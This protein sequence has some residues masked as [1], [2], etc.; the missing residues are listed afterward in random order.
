MSRDQYDNGY[1][2]G[3]RHASKREHDRYAEID[4]RKTREIAQLRKENRA[5]LKALADA[6]NPKHLDPCVKCSR[7]HGSCGTCRF[8]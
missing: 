5:L 1:A 8:K 6:Q 2:A 3:A 4:M 7:P